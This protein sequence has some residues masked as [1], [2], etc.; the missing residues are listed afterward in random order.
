M[1]S[2]VS[3][4]CS[5]HTACIPS[6]GGRGAGGGDHKK[7]KKKKKHHRVHLFM[8][9]LTCAYASCRICALI[10]D[11]ELIHEVQKKV[12][13]THDPTPRVFFSLHLTRCARQ[14]YI[15]LDVVRLM[16][17][18]LIRSASSLR[19]R[20]LIPPIISPLARAI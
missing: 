7:K 20:R 9:V 12:S 14:H 1:L 5:R 17:R 13:A 18:N 15:S 3:H 8:R 19:Q 4:L 6:R 10:L 16:T 2:D 11:H